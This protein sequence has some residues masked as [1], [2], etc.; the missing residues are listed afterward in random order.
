MLTD[1]Q[2][3]V[4]IGTLAAAYAESGRFKEA[5][6]AAQQAR[7]LAQAM[8][9]RDIAEKN[10][11]LLELYRAGKPYHEPPGKETTDGHR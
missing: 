11:E 9:E 7:D 1:N 3:P 6:A 2:V 10:S 5:I 4:V 8:G